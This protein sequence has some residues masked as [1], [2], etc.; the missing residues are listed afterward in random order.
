MATDLWYQSADIYTN[1]AA[2]KRSDLNRGITG[3]GVWGQAYL[4][5]DKYGD[6]G[7]QTLFGVSSSVDQRIKTDRRGIQGGVDY[8]FGSAVV[9]VTAGW[10][11]AE[12]ER[13]FSR[14]GF[15]ANGWNVGLYG[16][17]GSDVGFYGGL[18][19]KYDKAN[20][21]ADN[22]GLFAGVDNIDI[23]SWGVEGE[24]GYRVAVGSS[25]VDFGGG[26]AWVRS[27]ID[28]FT[29][30]GITF[31]PDKARSLRG[32]LGVRVEGGA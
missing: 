32:R 2:M 15:D 11:K 29:L 3:I 30:A 19:A 13:K 5:R 16:I 28:D 26:L 12:L 31:D 4:S 10:E 17:A 20:A 21:D 27:K 22:D 14:T 24:V 8:N 6:Q 1:Y 23:K 7:S 9:G 25:R 18:L